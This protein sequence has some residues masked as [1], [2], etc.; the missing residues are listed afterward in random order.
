MIWEKL[1]RLVI[2]LLFIAGLLAV[3]MWYLPLIRQNERMRKEVMRFDLQIEKQ[4]EIG[5]NLRNSIEALKDPKTVERLARTRLGVAKP[6]ETVIR[7]ETAKTNI[8]GLR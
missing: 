8:P 1:T 6:G 3:A 5:R 4:E 2:F 7:F